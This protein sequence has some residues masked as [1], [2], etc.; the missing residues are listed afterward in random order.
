MQLVPSR[1]GFPLLKQGPQRQA[2]NSIRYWSKARRRFWRLVSRGPRFVC[3]SSSWMGCNCGHKK[4]R[5]PLPGLCPASQSPRTGLQASGRPATCQAQSQTLNFIQLYCILAATLW[6]EYE[7]PQPMDE[8]AE[9]QE[10]LSDQLRTTQ[11]TMLNTN[12]LNSETCGPRGR[13]EPRS[14]LCQLIRPPPALLG[15][16]KRIKY[17]YVCVPVC[18]SF[19]VN[20]HCRN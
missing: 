3:R 13:Q 12:L 19:I 7:I 10:C 6:S 1:M 20:L 15:I 11:W 8:E 5:E 18:V 17:L 9:A 4:N 2:L 14:Y 16:R